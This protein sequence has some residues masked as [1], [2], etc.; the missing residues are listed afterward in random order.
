MSEEEP[1]KLSI[2]ERIALMKEKS[3]AAA[4]PPPPRPAPARTFARPLPA[5]P[6]EEP[7]QASSSE[8][9][10][11]ASG[12]TASKG[13]SVADK[14]ALMKQ[15][16]EA[17]SAASPPQA[18][19][20][21]GETGGKAGSGIAERIALMKASSVAAP[22]SSEKPTMLGEGGATRRL[23]IDRQNFAA[24]INIAGLNPNAP[25]PPFMNKSA[26]VASYAPPETSSSSASKKTISSI[27]ESGE[28]NHVS[29]CRHHSIKCCILIVYDKCCIVKLKAP[30]SI[31]GKKETL[32]AP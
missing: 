13:L 32:C 21:S 8:S 12:E 17:A 31:D 4:A 26:S 27:D 6:G 25:R 19:I 1:K 20:I 14:I 22:A 24:S 29:S 5:S 2:A 15:K 3:A 28:F 18:P 9:S 30:C 16:S 23:S 11:S 7:K 10:S